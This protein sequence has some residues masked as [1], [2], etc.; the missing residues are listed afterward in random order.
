[1]G[2]LLQETPGENLS[3]HHSCGFRLLV[4]LLTV[5]IMYKL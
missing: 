5:K 3:Y 2:D 4:D 1:L